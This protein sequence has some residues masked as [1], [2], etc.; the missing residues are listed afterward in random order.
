MKPQKTIAALMI[1]IS[2]AVTGWA[3]VD[4]AYPAILGL[5]GL[6][7]LQRRFIW[8][9]KPEKRVITSLLMLLLAMLFS[10]H[11]R[12]SGRPGW[13]AQEEVM[14]LAWQTVARY[15]LA[16]MILLLFIGSPQR[17]PISLGLFHLA[18]AICAGQVL[19]LNDRFI[20]FRLLELVSVILVVLYAATT[21]GAMTIRPAPRGSRTPHWVVCSLVLVTAANAGWIVSSVLYQHVEVLDYI[22][23]WFARQGIAFDRR[24]SPSSRVAFSTSGELSSIH[25][26]IHDQ[27]TTVVLSIRSD[28]TPG[29]LR[30]RAFDIYDRSQWFNSADKEILFGTQSMRP[31]P[32]HLHVFQMHDAPADER[33]N[34][35][36]R[37]EVEIDGDTI[38]TP[39]GTVALKALPRMIERDGHDIFYLRQRGHGWRYRFDYSTTPYQEA[40]PERLYERML[41]IPIHFRPQDRARLTDLAGRVFAGAQTTNEKIEAVVD[42]FRTN[43]TYS[44]S[45]EVPVDREPLL[46]FLFEAS[47]GYCE[48]FASATAI[49]LRLVGVPTRYVT[50]FL[51]TEK[52]PETGFWHARNMDAHAWV[53]AW[54]AQRG[55]WVT[56]ESTVQESR[57]GTGAMDQLGRLSGGVSVAFSR[58]VQAVYNYGLLGVAQWLFTSH[59]VVT[60]SV[61]LATVLGVIA[62]WVLFRRR[63]AGALKSGQSPPDPSLIALHK[64]LA[65]M[66]RRLGSL[67]QRRQL[68]E[69]LHTFARRLRAREA[70]DGLWLGVSDWYREY[71]ELRYRR[72]VSAEHLDQ[73]H[74]RGEGLRRAL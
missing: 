14:A 49:M 26:L 55:Q 65:R 25:D 8:D 30:A 54:D 9:I 62:W 42:Y 69:T 23:M 36:V 39:L 21:H 63:R 61:L 4:I 10:L 72:E 41:S 67:G 53:E 18:N 43:Y 2:S 20:T 13:N 66:D 3:C 46:Y 24:D 51:V 12:Y 17:L 45:M 32:N 68:S 35:V 56:V 64:M 73:L 29:Y 48:Y 33:N 38:F 74:R 19:L 44:L 47:S 11:Y 6:L 52:D 37:H 1:L 59:G 71:A 28:R 22:P 34:M 27:D 15:F 16:V 40:P 57:S 60:A 7:G 70:G 31:F 58:F 50:G 5:L